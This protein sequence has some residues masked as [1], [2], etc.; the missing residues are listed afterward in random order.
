MKKW[1]SVFV[2]AVCLVSQG[3]GA[4]YKKVD[5]PFLGS[6]KEFKKADWHDNLFMYR[7]AEKRAVDYKAFIFDPVL[8]Y[9]SA[10]SKYRQ[11]SEDEIIS[12]G[13]LFKTMSEEAFKT[14][15]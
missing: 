10:H 8:V 11:L 1:L 2:L 4:D 9:Q 7:H 15:V 12:V 13:R 14:E 3:K 5:S 6:V